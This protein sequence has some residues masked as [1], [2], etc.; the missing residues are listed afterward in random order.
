MRTTL[1]G[2]LAGLLAG[3][4]TLLFWLVDYGPGNNLHTVA[5]WLM[6]DSAGSGKQIG[7]LVWLV[8]S[9][10]FGLL[11][12]IVAR[13]WRPTLGSFSLLGP[14]IGAIEWLLVVFIIGT[15]LSHGQL[16][17]GGFL[18][19]VV[20]MLTYGLLLGNIAFQFQTQQHIPD[21]V[22]PER[23]TGSTRPVGN[24]RNGVSS[25]VPAPETLT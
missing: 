16:E 24:D 6:L 19:T 11:F 15:L 23:Q 2:G 25:Q 17:L 22:R 3:L 5:H 4:I 1:R 9:G 18:Y 20:P 7:F 12:G 8:L 21:N 13:V 10:L 14:V